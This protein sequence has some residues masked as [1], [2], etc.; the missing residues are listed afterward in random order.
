MRKRI[1]G[2]LVVALACMGAAQAVDGFSNDGSSLDHVYAEHW[3][4]AAITGPYL[5]NGDTAISIDIPYNVTGYT[6]FRF[7]SVADPA[8]IND[9]YDISYG[10]INVSL[11][12]DYTGTETPPTGDMAFWLRAYAGRVENGAWV[13]TGRKSWFCTAP[14]D[15][16]FRVNA[17]CVGTP[18]EPPNLYNGATSYDD[19]SIY[20]FRM[21]VVYWEATYT[22]NTISVDFIEFTKGEPP[23]VADA[24][25]D[26]TIP[27][28]CGS[29]VNVTL[30][31]SGT[32]GALPT[33]EYLWYDVADAQIGSGEIVNVDLPLGVHVF[34]LKVGEGC[35]W[36]EDTVIVNV[37]GN[38]A[39]FPLTY[40]MAQQINHY[41]PLDPAWN[42]I[43]EGANNFP[44]EIPAID[45]GPYW[46]A[47][48]YTRVW[49]KGLAWWYGPFVDLTK[50]CY[51]PLDLSS[52]GARLEFTAR[53]FQY[54]D[55]YMGVWDGTNPGTWP[56]LMAYEDAPIFP[57]LWDMYGKRMCLG[58]VYGAQHIHADPYNPP[59]ETIEVPLISDGSD[60]SDPDFDITKVVRIEF[61]GTCWGGAGL[62]YVDFK[63]V[64]LKMV[65]TT[66][67]GDTNCDGVVDTA[68]I[69][70]FVYVVVNGVAA[71][72]CPTSLEAA[73]TNGDSAVDTADIDSFVAAVV[74]GGCL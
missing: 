72:G 38:Q 42:V 62:D 35:S 61:F 21:D 10:E 68:D 49:P 1:V 48:A 55:D 23:P 43:Y 13:M 28:V 67:C 74:N 45:S 3:Q 44:M 9:P 33:T 50:D 46:P 8:P 22:S 73:D 47:G 32:V 16:D 20:M 40:S 19:T 2:A 26:Q 53:Y 11:K 25:A 65:Q 70:N 30:D 4:G 34:K 63:D 17:H 51:A 66:I 7:H 69:D 60:L 12:F 27:G 41:D 36:S 59:W 64:T 5:S 14:I 71:P 58:I 6:F 31:G 18:G 52:P 39:T 29:L 24:G 37:E 56:D 54:P 57:R 15:G